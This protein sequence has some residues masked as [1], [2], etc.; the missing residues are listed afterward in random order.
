MLAGR[1][2]RR[3]VVAGGDQAERRVAHVR[4]FLVGDEVLGRDDVD[5][6]LAQPEILDRLHHR[7][8]LRAGRHEDEEHVGLGVLDPLHE[9]R[10]I[11]IV[12]R[13]ADRADDLAAG[14]GEALGEG[15][16]GVMPGDEV[17]DRGVGLLPALFGGPFAERQRSLP[18][19]ERDA[20]DVGRDPRD[21]DARRHW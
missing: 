18:Q 14:I 2:G 8:G 13:E 5:A 15:G 21:R 20:R 3:R 17:A 10:E 11:G 12:G 6:G 1:V 19:R 7:G 9:R 4:Q 16:F